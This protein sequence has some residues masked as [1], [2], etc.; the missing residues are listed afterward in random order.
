MVT[1]KSNRNASRKA[2]LKISPPPASISLQLRVIAV[3]LR[4]ALSAVSV[5][6]HAL[7]EQNADLDAD[8]AVVLQRGAGAPLHVGLERIEALLAEL[9]GR[10][11][12]RGRA[13][14]GRVH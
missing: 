4:C 12:T 5:A 11:G 8:V 9:D 6:A 13:G 7:R 10:Q 3:E 1:A 2:A 14:P